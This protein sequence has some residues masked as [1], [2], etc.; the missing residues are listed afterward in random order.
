MPGPPPKDPATRRRRNAGPQLSKLPRSGRP[1]DPPPWPLPRQSKAEKA[2]WA[3]LWATPQATQWEVGAWPRTVARYVRLVLK[4]ESPSA[5]AGLHTEVRQLEDRLG[6]SPMAML[7][8]RWEVVDDDAA[9]DAPARP[10]LPPGRA[11][12]TGTDGAPSNVRDL[13]PAVDPDDG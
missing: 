6:L 4:A 1:G 11:R 2:L 9:A 5:P 7:R 13:F 12:A 8:L 3:D 10:A